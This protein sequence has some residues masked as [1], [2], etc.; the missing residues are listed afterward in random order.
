MSANRATWT[1][2]RIEQLKSCF[3]AGL[4]CSQIAREIGATR[5]AVIGK[6]HRL[7]LSRPKDVLANGLKRARAAKNAARPKSFGPKGLGSKSWRL[8]IVDQR[9]LLIAAFPGS[10]VSCAAVDSA[11]KCTLLELSQ[12]K[13][14]WP[15]NDPGAHDFGFCG[16]EPV[17]GLPYCVGHARIAYRPPGRQR[18]AM[19]S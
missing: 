4:T 1:T 7:G 8:T 15:I 10:A 6:M 2:E 5:N 18:I 16:N 19:R 13:C 17:N 11:Q 3:N 12:A 14:R 9:D